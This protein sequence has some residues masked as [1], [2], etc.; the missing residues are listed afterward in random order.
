[1]IASVLRLSRS[2][3]KELNIRD[4]YSL[5]KVVYSL[6]PQT[7]NDKRSF[8][9][10]DKGGNFHERV[11]LLLSDTPPVKQNYGEIE[12]RPIP[13]DFL[14]KN[15]YGFEIVMNPVM[16]DN[17]SRKLIPVKGKDNM[18]V[19]FAQKASGYGFHI[20]PNSLSVKETDVITFEKGKDKIVLSKAVFI[21]KLKVTN[22]EVFIK[23]FKQGLGRGKAFGFGLFQIIPITMASV[24]A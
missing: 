19:W 3:C 20:L 4:A 23:S 7:N 18:L 2:D 8:L 12:S 17:K 1:M 16:R 11:I 15:F 13:S 21:G 14:E 5:H 24:N 22:R 6:F 10:C 9:Y